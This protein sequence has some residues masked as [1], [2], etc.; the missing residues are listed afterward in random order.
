MK[1]LLV[2]LIDFWNARML[3]ITFLSENSQICHETVKFW[4][5]KAPKIIKMSDLFRKSD[6]SKFF[7][8]FQCFDKKIGKTYVFPQKP[9]IKT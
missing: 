5:A 6:V 2:F 3:F 8:N 9:L 7:V 1:T 4:A